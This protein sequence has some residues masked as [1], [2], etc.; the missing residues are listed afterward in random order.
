LVV[1][2][3]LGTLGIMGRHYR[4]DGW[5]VTFQKAVESVL[6]QANTLP[7]SFVDFEIIPPWHGGPNG[8][9]LWFIC[10]T[11]AN[12]NR[13]RSEALACATKKVVDSMVSKGFPSNAASTLETNV[14]SLE[15]MERVGN[16]F[17]YFR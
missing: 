11:E 14:T 6:S 10:D 2:G 15:D 3:Y 7:V 13:F 8:M 12:R 4:G 5:C 17:Y 16:R 9:G 1:A